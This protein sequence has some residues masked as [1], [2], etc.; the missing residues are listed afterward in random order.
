MQNKYLYFS[1]F[2]FLILILVSLNI[3]FFWD[4]TFFSEIAV[5]YFN[6]NFSEI[7]NNEIPDTGG[8]PMYSLYLA[9]VWKIFGKSLVVSH[10]AVLPF[11]IVIIIEYF[12][13]AKR[14]LQPSTIKHAFILLIAEPVLS[15]QAILMGYDILMVC[16]FM[17]ALNA[18]LNERKWT[19]SI[20]LVF[21]C[22]SS[23][24]GIMLGC[25]LFV[26]DM[27]IF[28]KA[29][30]IFLKYIPAL[31]ALII[32]T[33][34]HKEKTGWLFFSPLREYTDEAWTSPFM[35]LK[36]I[37][38][39]GWKLVDQGRIILWSF[40]VFYGLVFFRRNGTPEFKLLSTII[41][42][43]L[44]I[45]TIWMS[46]LSNPIGP[47]YFLGIFLLLNIFV[48]Y[49]LQSIPDKIIRNICAGLFTISL[50]SGNFWIYPERYGNAWD[51]SLKVIPY[52][53]LKDQMDEFILQKNISNKEIGTQYPLIADTRFSN[54]SDSSFSYTNVWSGPI[55]DYSYFLQTNIINTDIPFQ[56]EEVKA[57][58]LLVKKFASGQVY[59]SL[60]KNPGE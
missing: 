39:I 26:I 48:C 8:F 50:V 49:L 12:K 44:L 3:P 51:S 23:M 19:F 34:F 9:A 13:L 46:P 7:L 18:L 47:K 41:F 2:F 5:H 60:Y 17:I 6:N 42:I 20:A 58:W 1:L 4:G 15:T 25:S 54:L 22:M 35:T 52:F 43:P 38:Y 45:L 57:S 53:K 55:S 36:K 14:F 31:I 33:L 16:F 24:R 21:L 40:V 11:L 28:K 30:I 32:W 27:F 56:V 37:F 10:L 59:I 29:G